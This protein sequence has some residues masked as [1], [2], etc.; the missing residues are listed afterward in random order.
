MSIELTEQQQKSLDSLG[1]TP[2]RLIDPR[3]R[4]TYVLIPEVDYASMREVL[5][6]DRRQR[7]IRAVG[8]RNAMGRFEPS[9]IGRNLD[10][11]ESGVELNPG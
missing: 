6:E 1:E 4:T 10:V 9:P 3:S 8:R 2:P 7:E 5:E 11:F